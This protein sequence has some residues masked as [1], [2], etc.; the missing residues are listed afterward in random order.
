MK[1]GASSSKFASW[2]AFYLLT[3]FVHV[4]AGLWLICELGNKPVRQRN[5]AP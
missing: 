5:Y 3:M 2:G 4:G 1:I